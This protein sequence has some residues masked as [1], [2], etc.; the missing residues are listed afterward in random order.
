MEFTDIW[1]ICFVFFVAMLAI[2]AVCP[3]SEEY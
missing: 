3:R 1:L 2:S